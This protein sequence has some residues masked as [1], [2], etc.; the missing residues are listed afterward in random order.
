[1][2]ISLPEQV[3]LDYEPASIGSRGIA[4]A[5][6]MILRWTVLITVVLL[7][8]WL[9]SSFKSLVDIV[10]GAISGESGSKFGHFFIAGAIFIALFIELA[11][12]IYFEVYRE[13][14]T[15]GKKLFGL[16]V[17]DESGLPITFRTSLTRTLFNLID[18]QSTAG[19]AA[20]V[21][22]MVSSKSQRLG[23]LAAST[24]VV[25]DPVDSR[26]GTVTPST[27]PPLLVT[28]ETFAAIETFIERFDELLPVA[29]EK[30]A[31]QLQNRLAVEHKELE[32]N[33]IQSIAWFKA[34]YARLVPRKKNQLIQDTSI[35]W[36]ALDAE[37]TAIESYYANPKLL[38]EISTEEI[39]Q[40]VEKYQL[41]CQ[42][43]AYLQ[44]YYPQTN[45]SRRAARLVREGRQLLYGNRLAA[46]TQA[47][48]SVVS[49]VPEQFVQLKGYVQAS[50]ACMILGSLLSAMLVFIHP[51]F[52]FMFVS[53]ETARQ[54]QAGNLWTEQIQ[55]YSAIASS[56]IMTNNIRVTY[57]AFVS[58]ITAGVLTAIVLFF[59]GALLGGIFTVL[60][61]FD[62]MAWKLFDFVTAHGIL[63]LSIIAVAGGV[64]FYIGDALIKPGA[65]TRKA[66]FTK[67]AIESIDIMVF[68]TLCLILA[69]LVE[70]YISPYSYYP[71]SLK[72]AV[73]SLL[74]LAYWWFLTRKLYSNKLI[75]TVR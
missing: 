28:K 33:G 12:P 35:D 34:L 31:E 4:F 38:K 52:G 49:R 40:F 72:L 56:K 9:S 42:R 2:R 36:K 60:G 65:Q 11:Y 7:L 18:F 50:A 21:S 48:T 17:V 6:D 22:A 54:L 16:R 13:G 75:Q 68:N 27:E 67:R 26:V 32:V 71:Y 73:G 41:L 74:G 55:G 43:L 45:Q 57:M 61:R 44:T 3:W 19:F 69:G 1:M 37:F 58:G 62:G 8:A 20:I 46:Q 10:A 51:G 29:R 5:L 25:Y 63:E 47:E 53:E 66:A 23:D 24:I 14:V 30:V 15:P 39:F 64:G 59:N 70:G